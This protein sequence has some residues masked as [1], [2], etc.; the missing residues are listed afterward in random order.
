[1]PSFEQDNLSQT[2]DSPVSGESFDSLVVPLADVPEAPDYKVDFQFQG[3]SLDAAVQ[4]KLA[5]FQF[6]EISFTALDEDNLL[7]DGVDIQSPVDEISLIDYYNNGQIQSEL[8]SANKVSSIYYQDNFSTDTAA[9]V[10]EDIAGGLN[11][12]ISNLSLSDAASSI[13]FA[14]E[15][16]NLGSDSN[17][18]DDIVNAMLLENSFRNDSDIQ[19][20][21]AG[22][23]IL[24]KVNEKSHALFFDNRIISD[25]IFAGS[26][27]QFGAFSAPMGADAIAPISADSPNVLQGIARSE[28]SVGSLDASDYE[29]VVNP[30]LNSFPDIGEISEVK[31]AGY[32][33]E[34]FEILGDG[35]QLEMTPYII[36]ANDITPGKTVKI[37]DPEI[38]LSNL[39]SYVLSTVAVYKIRDVVNLETGL[40]EDI[41]ILIK[42]RPQTATL[43][44]GAKFPDPP[45]DVNYTYDS[46]NKNL[47]IHWDFSSSNTTS[48]VKKFQ[49]FRRES[50]NESFT[51][52]RQYDFDDSE[53]PVE[54]IEDIDFGLNVKIGE[55]L[56]FY[57]DEDFKADKEY[58]YAICSISEDGASSQYSVQTMV[59]YSN[60]ER[61]LLLK[62]VSQ[63]GAPKPYPNFYIDQDLDVDIM[64]T[65]KSNAMTVY[66]DP[67][68][69]NLR[70]PGDENNDGIVDPEETAPIQFIRTNRTGGKY[71]MQLINTDLLKEQRFEITIDDPT[72]LVDDL[73]GP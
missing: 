19:S 30:I 11:V 42:S 55:P 35:S 45:T 46:I 66:L 32:V 72:T 2:G 16:I 43:I 40:L 61:K 3:F 41:E 29:F 7:F 24:G 54:Q 21:E 44:A 13:L 62:K 49:I 58:I 67:D 18:S 39:Y 9:Q 31:I 28:Y 5:D 71:I 36:S 73:S 4:E 60:A 57:I 69:F 33:V 65:S 64:R 26:K 23:S 38:I 47:L 1:L 50:I 10:I 15:S 22:L 37:Q 12:D 59:K 52:I 14:A 68:V 25:A 34:K 17:I 63:S 6:V 53:N 20:F 27:S 56:T 48:L 51:L 70:I 8:I